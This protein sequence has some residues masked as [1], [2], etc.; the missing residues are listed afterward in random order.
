MAAPKI[1]NNT[2]KRG[3][4]PLCITS[5]KAMAVSRIERMNPVTYDLKLPLFAPAL[6]IGARFTYS[7]PI[8]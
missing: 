1:T 2:V 7:T 4:P 3:N 5:A 8:R 6:S